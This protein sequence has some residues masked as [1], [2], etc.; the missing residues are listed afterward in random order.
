M[1][2]EIQTSWLKYYKNI[3]E[4]I[5]NE[6]Y[7]DDSINKWGKNDLINRSIPA[8]NNE[9]VDEINNKVIYILSIDRVIAQ[10]LLWQMIMTLLQINL[11]ISQ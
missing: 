10:F 7:S 1:F 4:N 9:V 6:L 8:A 11:W 5:F 3:M 2:I